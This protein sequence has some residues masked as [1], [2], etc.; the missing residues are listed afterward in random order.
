MIKTMIHILQIK[1]NIF[2]TWNFNFIKK[3]LLVACINDHIFLELYSVN[4][5]Q[6]VWW[7]ICFGRASDWV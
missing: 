6:S 7:C 5:C 3:S 1:I 4:N 2:L